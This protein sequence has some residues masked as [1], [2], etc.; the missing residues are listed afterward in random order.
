MLSTCN[1]QA[2][3][4][5][6]NWLVGGDVGYSKFKTIQMGTTN[7]NFRIFECYP[8]LGYF[9][10][11]KVAGGLKLTSRFS[12]GKN[13]QPDG[14]RTAQTENRIGAGPFFRYYFLNTSNRVNAFTDASAHYTVVTNNNVG[15]A[16]KSWLYD[17]SAGAVIFF[18]IN[19][20]VEF[21]LTYQYWNQ[22]KTDLRNKNLLFKIGLQVHL[23]KE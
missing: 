15:L 4:T 19:V 14:T 7:I 20:G 10:I 3:L 9:F 23:E 17:L 6:G 11:D 13:L 8:R 12:K 2:Q 16:D 18:N 1:S 5:K 22:L 21:L